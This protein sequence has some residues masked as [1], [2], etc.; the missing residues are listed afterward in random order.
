VLT[1]T[2]RATEALALFHTAASRWNPDV[3]IRLVPD[4]AEL[5][6]LLA[7]VPQE[8][9]VATAVG[10]ITVYVP[11]GVDGVVDAGDHNVLSI[12]GA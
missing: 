11:P 4:G 12:S 10:A 3:Q 5:K 8:G 6:P 9:D 1:F 7:D 2:D